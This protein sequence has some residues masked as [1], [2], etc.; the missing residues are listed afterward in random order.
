[1]YEYLP[2]FNFDGVFKGI[3]SINILLYEVVAFFIVLS[4]LLI[5]LR[6]LK[7][8][9]STFEK[10]LSFT[11]ILGIPSKLLGALVGFIEGIVWSFIICYIVSL[12]LFNI[13]G[14]KDSKFRKEI[15]NKTP[16]LTIFTNDVVDAIEEFTE[17][18]DD[19][20]NNKKMS[21][22]EFNLKT[23]DLMLKYKITTV[24]SVDK[25]REKGK[26]KIPKINKI[27]DK[28]REDE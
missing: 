27:I 24:E 10:L 1:M 25:L 14:V 26:L 6:L 11:V 15:L 28:Y 9:T 16:I 23:L 12:P 7:F 19:Y 13:N 2:F 18:K 4:I 17:I 3:T 22:D 5:L 8:I 21:S 20:Q